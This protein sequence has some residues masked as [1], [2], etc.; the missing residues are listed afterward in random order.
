MR[1]ALS[2]TDQVIAF[3][4]RAE[5]TPE[6]VRETLGLVPEDEFLSMLDLVTERRAGDIF[7]AIGR[8]ADAGIDFG[9]FLAGFADVLRAQLAIA[10]GG[11][12][13]DLSTHLRGALEE[14]RSR[15]GPSDVLRM[16]AAIT[17]LE[18]RFRK[19]GQQQLL[20]ETLLVRCALLDQ[21]VTLESLL[22]SLGGGA[23]APRTPEP[24][25]PRS[26]GRAPPQRVAAARAPAHPTVPGATGEGDG[27]GEAS[28]RRR[29]EPA[30]VAERWGAVIERIRDGQS[31]KVL[32]IALEHADPSTGSAPGEIVLALAEPN[33]FYEQAIDAGRAE[34]LAALRAELSGVEQVRL[35]RAGR[36]AGTPP[37]RLTAESAKAEQVATLRK[38]D[39]VLGAAIDA[40]DLELLE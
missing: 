4:D 2:L 5:V 26:S 17:D 22:Q 20:L 3:D 8:L 35:E 12:P 9:A 11:E 36:P 39:A 33:A 32:A 10:L 21:T 7:A 34:I 24:P 23:P 30:A 15:V 28:A 29:G 1:D 18:P 25:L 16:L 40:L 31:K 13:P 19:S 27:E 37:R 6:R 14:R 38:K